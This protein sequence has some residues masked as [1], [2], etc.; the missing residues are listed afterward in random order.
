MIV[1][2]TNV[3]IAYL[4]GDTARDTQAMD[5]ALANGVLRMV[6]VVLAELLSDPKLDGSVESALNDVPL[7]ELYAGFWSRTGKLRSKLLEKGWKPKLADT[8][9]AQTCLDSGATLL[10]RDSDFRAFSKYGLL[11][12]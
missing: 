12:G 5:D 4:A 8:L 3:W 9:I 11:L 1:A 7:L 2:D 10:T 6:P